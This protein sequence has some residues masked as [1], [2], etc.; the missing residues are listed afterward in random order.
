[1]EWTGRA[2]PALIS[3]KVRWGIEGW[4]HGHGRWEME[5]ERWIMDWSYILFTQYKVCSLGSCVCGMAVMRILMVPTL[6]VFCWSR[7]AGFIVGGWYKSIF[8]VVC[9]MIYFV[10][11]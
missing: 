10:D 7:C 2:P 4:M 1:M 3:A 11:F 6:N 5:D 8:R 9:L